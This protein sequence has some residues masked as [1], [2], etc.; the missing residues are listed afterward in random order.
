MT[1]P[2]DEK[3]I[4]RIATTSAEGTG[5]SS[6]G[7]SGRRTFLEAL[8]GLGAASVGALLSLPLIRFFLHPALKVSPPSP[9]KEVGNIKEFVSATTPVKKLVKIEQRDGWR[10]VIS[11]RPLYVCKDT[12]GKLCAF[13]AVCPH[14]GCTVSWHD[15]KNSFVCPCH[16]GQF[17]AE[18]RLLGGP[19]PRG[20]D[21]LELKTDGEMLMVQYRNFRQLVPNKEEIA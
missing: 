4:G 6:M 17:T 2:S 19:P 21:T 11:D 10:K 20:L 1:D 9:W 8:L 7:V 5:E 12:S 16:N 18:G 13:S 14:L 3:R 15:E